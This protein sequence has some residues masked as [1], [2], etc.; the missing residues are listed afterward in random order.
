MHPRS[1]QT[2]QCLNKQKSFHTNLCFF[3][4]RYPIQLGTTAYY[5]QPIGD[6]LVIWAMKDFISMRES[7]PSSLDIWKAFFSFT[8]L[9]LI[10][11]PS[12]VC[13]N[14]LTPFSTTEA[15]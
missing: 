2:R 11:S 1:C 4:F 15:L 5:Y 9:S 3:N 13:I 7:P 14:L 12:L 8:A 6:Y 10:S